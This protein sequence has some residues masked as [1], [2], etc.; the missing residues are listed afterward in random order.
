[1]RF[2]WLLAPGLFAG[3][4]LNSPAIPEGRHRG[5]APP[6]GL[7]DSEWAQ[8]KSSYEQNRH[9]AAPDASGYHAR[10]WG[11][12][13]SI[14]FDGR[15]FSVEPDGGGWT[16]G[17]ELKSYG[18]SGYKQTVFGIAEISTDL[19]KIHYKRGVLE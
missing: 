19:D 15:G 16:W 12:Q 14:H 17:L 9:K 5:A 18:R 2:V 3:L 8:I 13:W 6:K 11:Q 10:N 4:L 1:M 7:K